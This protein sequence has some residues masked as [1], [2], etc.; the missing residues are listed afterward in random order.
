MSIIYG[1]IG[2]LAMVFAFGTV[3]ANNFLLGFV[4]MGVGIISFIISLYYILK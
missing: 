4:S 2:V 1:V 3:E